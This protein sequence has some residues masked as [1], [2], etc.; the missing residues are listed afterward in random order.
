MGDPDKVALRTAL[1]AA[2]WNVERVE[3]EAWW[4]HEAWRLS[5]TWRPR[6]ALAYVTLMLS[7]DVDTSRVSSAGDVWRI[8]VSAEMPQDRLEHGRLEI[9]VR[10]WPD[11]LRDIVSAAAALRPK[12]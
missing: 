2:G 5:S 4:V 1:E 8:A 10:P 9:N 6:D 11:R 7:P 3:H 12:A